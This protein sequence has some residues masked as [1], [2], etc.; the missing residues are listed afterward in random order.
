V[1]NGAA[2]SVVILE[3]DLYRRADG[4]AV[5]AFLAA[6]KHVVVIDHLAH[7]SGEKADVVLPAAT[8]AE[9]DGTLVNH[10]GRAQRSFQVFV[11][12]SDIQESWRWIEQIAA[13]SGHANA[14]QSFDEMTAA[15]AAA[16][17]SLAGIVR[18]AP[19]AVF[20]IAE[21]K[22]PRTSHRY[23]GQTAMHAN[24]SVFDREPISDPDSALAFSMEGYPGQPPAALIPRFWAPGWNSIQSLNKFQQEVG[25]ALRGGGAGV[26]LIEPGHS[27]R[28]TY[29]GEAP[30]AFERRSD[31]WLVV[32]LHHVFG[33]EELSVLSPGIAE[34]APAPYLALNPDDAAALDLGAGDTAQ[35]HLGTTE[36]RLPVRLE[37]SLQ[38]GI[39]GLPV[40]LPGI[41]AVVLPAAGRVTKEATP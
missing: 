33:S 3:N 2:D 9:S 8:F 34:L 35:L 32:P 29:R 19:R 21:Q 12:D 36:L 18:A 23:S 24:V 5:D 10:E 7:A 37:P 28:A 6:A 39:A 40:G 17:P 13:A 4:A 20:R 26:R 15:C 22:I 38:H 41:G 14:A 30:A 11:P 31:V 27:V 25:G 16:L 1:K